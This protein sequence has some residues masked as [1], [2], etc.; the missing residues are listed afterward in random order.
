MFLQ[1]TRSEFPQ[2]QNNTRELRSIKCL[3]NNWENAH[4]RILKHHMTV[5][6]QTGHRNSWREWKTKEKFRR[7]RSRWL[8]FTNRIDNNKSIWV[9]S[10]KYQSDAKWVGEQKGIIHFRLNSIAANLFIIRRSRTIVNQGL[11]R[12]FS[13]PLKYLM[14]GLEKISLIFFFSQRG[15]LTRKAKLCHTVKK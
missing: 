3:K 15:Q 13:L 11:S 12:F 8:M 7:V 4:A 5:F 9:I 10:V 1:P 2:D 14:S 6:F